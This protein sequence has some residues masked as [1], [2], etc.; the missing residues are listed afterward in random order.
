[1]PRCFCSCFKKTSDRLKYISGWAD[2][3]LFWE[4]ITCMACLFLSGLNCIFHWYA[5][6][7]IIS[8]SL[9]NWVAATSFS[10]TTV[11]KEVSSAKSRASELTFSTRSLMYTRKNRGPRTEPWGTPARISDHSEHFPFKTTRCLRF[12]RYEIINFKRPP[13]AQ[14]SRPWNRDR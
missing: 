9:F 10:Y 5:H 1:M 3:S 11:N 8:R 2:L 13:Y 6:W 12:E 14:L 4:K 7:D